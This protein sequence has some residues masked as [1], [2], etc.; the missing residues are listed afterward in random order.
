[1]EENKTYLEVYEDFMEEYDKSQANG[2]R[3]GQIIAILAQ[4][5]CTCNQEYAHARSAFDRVA[6]VIAGTT[7]ES[8][9]KPIS[10]SKAD[11]LAAATPENVRLTQAKVDVQ[12]VEQCIN[13]IKCLQRGIMNEFSHTGNM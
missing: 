6:A 9:G 10:S 7:D 5:Y 4:Y 1:M 2:E 8:S 3:A 11:V 13:A 12:N